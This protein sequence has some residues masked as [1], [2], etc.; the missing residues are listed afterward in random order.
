M[1]E[2][3]TARRFHWGS[4]Y[5]IG[6]IGAIGWIAVLT[7]PLLRGM[8]QSIAFASSSQQAVPEHAAATHILALAEHTAPD[9]GALTHVQET[10]PFVPVL[11]LVTTEDCLECET[12]VNTWAQAAQ[13][14][15]KGSAGEQVELWIVSTV[16]APVTGS[17]VRP[18]LTT[19]TVGPPTRRL[20]ILDRD[21]F[22][23]YTGISVAPVALTFRTRDTYVCSIAGVPPPEQA[24]RCIR[25]MVAQDTPK[26]TVDRHPSVVPIRPDLSQIRP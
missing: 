12:A 22:I 19:T 4:L 6:L 25:A 13:Q 15:V 26:L 9:G 8:W 16:R 1:F 20:E 24:E 18:R 2:R 3:R 14:T 11:Y 23:A 10:G 17:V 5:T 7:A 21:R